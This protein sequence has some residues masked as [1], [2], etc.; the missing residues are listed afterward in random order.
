MKMPDK[1]YLIDMVDEIVLSDDP[2][3]GIDMDKNDSVEYV[4]KNEYEPD[5]DARDE[6]IRELLSEIKKLNLIALKPHDKRRIVNSSEKRKQDIEDEKS[7]MELIAF[8]FCYAA[9]VACCGFL[10]AVFAP[11]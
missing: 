8:V 6:T 7:S 1:I 3:P 9:L 5:Y 2:A 11:S 4:R 10:I